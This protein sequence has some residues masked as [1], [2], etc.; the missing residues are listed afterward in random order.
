MATT[1]PDRKM[2]QAAFHQPVLVAETTLNLNARQGGVYLD[3]TVGEGGHALAILETSSPSGRVL[4]IDLHPP[5]LTYAA[6]R[7]QQ[8]GQRF[9][10]LQGNYANM[11]ALAR[12]SGLAQVDGVLL[13]LGFSGRQ[14]REPGFGFGS[15]E[16]LDMRFDPEAELTAE[17]IVNTFSEKELAQLIFQYGEEPRSRAIARS[18]VRG[19]PIGSATELAKLVAVS[20]GP[21]WRHK[22]HPATRTFQALRM[23]VNSELSNLEKGLEAAIQLLDPEGRLVVISYHSLEDRVVKTF[24]AR[25]RATCICPPEVLFCVCGHHPRLQQ[26]NRRVIKPSEEEVRSNPRS[27]SARMRVAQRL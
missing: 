23:V 1:D 27:R 8:Y 18:L 10:Y 21:R 6:E 2:R 3:A 14:I 15:D 20:A 26:V 24:M 5:S 9:T 17:Q 16:P 7:L 25:E 22:V 11:L 4:G 12:A 13:D 19:R